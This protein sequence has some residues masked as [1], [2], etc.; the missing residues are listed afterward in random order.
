MHLRLQNSH[1]KPI[2]K[3]NFNFKNDKRGS[4]KTY[5]RVGKKNYNNEK[6]KIFTEYLLSACRDY[7]F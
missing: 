6:S 2:Q 3:E 5:F 4:R 1:I 7:D